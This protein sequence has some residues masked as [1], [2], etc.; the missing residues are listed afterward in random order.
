[1]A[2][3]LLDSKGKPIDAILIV[4][5]ITLGILRF[6][7]TPRLEIPTMSG[8]Y[9]AAAHIFVGGL[10]GAWIVKPAKWIW[11]A[12]AIAITVVEVVAF[13]IQKYQ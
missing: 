11:L 10:I 7:I 5:G 8:S 13:M 3:K 2:I 6:T 1:V 12:V 4:V 9:E